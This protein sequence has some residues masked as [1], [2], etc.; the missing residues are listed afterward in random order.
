MV[1]KLLKDCGLCKNDEGL[2]YPPPPTI[3]AF[4]AFKVNEGIPSSIMR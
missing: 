2:S 3:T 4:P 1:K